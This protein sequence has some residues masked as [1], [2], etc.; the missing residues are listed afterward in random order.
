MPS[1]GRASSVCSARRDLD[2]VA[3]PVKAGPE[4][5]PARR[6]REHGALGLALARDQEGAVPAGGRGDGDLHGEGLET[7]GRWGVQSVVVSEA[8]SCRRDAALDGSPSSV[9]ALSSCRYPT[10]ASWGFIT[11]V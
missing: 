1:G 4:A 9:V 11:R 5:Q 10:T 7:G 3:L 6:P 2:A 8:C